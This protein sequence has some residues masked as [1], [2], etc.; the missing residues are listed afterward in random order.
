MPQKNGRVKQ[1]SRARAL[2]AQ[3]GTPNIRS[4]FL[5][6]ASQSALEVPLSNAA[7][8][9][10][11]TS[12]ASATEPEDIVQP[13]GQPAT[14][15]SRDNSDQLVLGGQLQH[16]GQPAVRQQVT[17]AQQI[18]KSAADRTREDQDTA[19]DNAIRKLYPYSPREGQRYAL[20]KLIYNRNDL[21]LIAKTSFGKSMILQSVSILLNK[22]ITT[23]ILPLNQIG[24]EQAEYIRAIGGTPCFLNSDTMREGGSGLLD[25]V[26]AGRYS[27]VLLSPELAMSREFHSVA[28]DPGFK[29]RLSLVVIDEAHLVSLWGRNFR[30]EYA[31]LS[32]LRSLFGR[33]IPWFACSA[34]LDAES[35]KELRVGAG[36]EDD[37][38]V[39]RTS[40]DRPELAI[41][42]GKIKKG[43]KSSYSALRFLFDQAVDPEI[44]PGYGEQTCSTSQTATP[45]RIPKTVIFFDSRKQAN[46]A[47]QVMRRYLQLLSKQ[48]T[49]ALAK[50]VVRVYHRNTAETDK[51]SIINEFKKAFQSSEARVIF[52][53]EAIGIGVDVKDIRVV[54][55]YGLPK[56]PCFPI[57]WQRGGRA[58]RDGEEGEIILLVDEWIW[59]DRSHQQ[60]SQLQSQRELSSLSVEDSNLPPQKGKG[61]Q[62]S[63]FQR[64]SELPDEVYL[65]VNLEDGCLR[66]A[67]L[68][69]FGE[70][71]EFRAAINRDR[72]CSRCNPG[73]LSL[74]DICRYLYTENGP[75]MT[76]RR[77]VV[78]KK[79][80]DWLK[81]IST[82]IYENPMFEPDQYSIMS[83][84]LIYELAVR[85]DE[86]NS[87]AD[88]QK[89]SGKWELYNMYEA[90]LFAL[91]NPINQAVISQTSIPAPTV[92]SQGCSKRPIET[93]AQ[94]SLQVPSPRAPLSTMSGNRQNSLL[95]TTDSQKQCKLNTII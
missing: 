23:V 12:F 28:I 95:T 29:E 38:E 62:K 13:I 27:H 94:Q 10:A 15:K 88:L 90:D 7:S 54:V 9:S 2:S 75:K 68:D 8:L 93:L 14:E 83:K 42:L 76:A 71:Q 50:Q 36:F 81:I 56:E 3:L 1:S 39:Y 24:E 43:T 25:Q 16:G 40:I 51:K 41:R 44:K 46:E 45:E 6:H 52:A 22:S 67:I 26:K 11:N 69:Y 70:P 5:P 19:I 65:L 53:T 34:T 31:R 72:C 59:G 82:T 37:V 91:V 74:D 61:K 58:G 30:K 20:R 86:I 79:L 49:P 64:R 66:Q 63:E 21:I 89:I 18:I 60:K 80:E 73:M 55:L 84:E 48:Y 77:K 78:M 35:L 47:A 17:E 85:S 92:H 32:Q 87:T 33:Q 4:H 57:I